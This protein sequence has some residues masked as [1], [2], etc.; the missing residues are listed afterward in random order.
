MTKMTTRRQRAKVDLEPKPWLDQ[1]LAGC[2]FKD[3]RLGKRFRT[4]LE[5][6]TQGL[7]QSIPFACQDWASTKAA[8]RFFANDRVNEAEILAGHF[9]A[10]RDRF[11]ATKGSILVVHDTT[12]LSYQREDGRPIG[13]LCKSH[14]G[15]DAMGRPR[16]HTVCGILMHSSLAVTTEGL[17]LGL[18]AMKFWTRRHFKVS[19][20]LTTPLSLARRG[21]SRSGQVAATGWVRCQGRSASNSSTVVAKGSFRNK[22]TRYV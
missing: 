11:A 16:H 2:R 22:S 6:L 8:Y 12:E 3:E 21:C 10:T 15:S 7:G 19:A 13:V 20:L 17:P 5:Q 4:L 9:R 14:A 1:E 18:A